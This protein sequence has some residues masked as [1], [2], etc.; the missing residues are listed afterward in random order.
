MV[1]FVNQKDACYDGIWWAKETE[2]QDKRE[3][4]REKDRCEFEAAFKN[5]GRMLDFYTKCVRKALGEFTAGK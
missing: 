3:K 1:V 5:Q 2:A 4:E